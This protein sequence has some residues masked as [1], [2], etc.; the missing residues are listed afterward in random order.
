MQDIH[1]KI[2][3]A[4]KTLNLSNYELT[5]PKINKD[6]IQLNLSNNYINI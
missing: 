2:R 3:M 6:I 4:D 1:T 5:I